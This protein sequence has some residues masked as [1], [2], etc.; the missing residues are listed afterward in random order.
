MNQWIVDPR[1]AGQVIE[2]SYRIGDDGMWHRRTLDRADRTETIEQADIDAEPEGCE[3]PDIV[4]NHTKWTEA[5]SL[6]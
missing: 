3:V 2:R 6:A 1:D 5:E 4:R